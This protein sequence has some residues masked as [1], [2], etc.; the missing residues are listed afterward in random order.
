[1]RDRRSKVG[2]P[3]VRLG[4]GLEGSWVF[5]SIVRTCP[6]SRMC[7]PPAS[8]HPCCLSPGSYH[9]AAL[10]LLNRL[11]C[12]DPLEEMAPAWLCVAHTL[13][14]HQDL[15]FHVLDSTGG[16]LSTSLW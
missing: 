6:C 16:C 13:H 1:M 15:V 3:G 12:W 5:F 7:L 14:Q 4:E 11:H 9:G 2:K 8:L 10:V